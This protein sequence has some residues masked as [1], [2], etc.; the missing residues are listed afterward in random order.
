MPQD[1]PPVVSKPKGMDIT[2]KMKLKI[3]DL[4]AKNEHASKFT[5]DPDFFQMRVLEVGGLTTSIEMTTF[6]N[7][8]SETFGVY[9]PF[10]VF[11]ALSTDNPTVEEFFQDNVLSKKKQAPPSSANPP[12]RKPT[13]ESVKDND[14]KEGSSQ[15]CCV[16]S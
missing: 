9:I 2:K 14:K 16:I 15:S 10:S 8:I 6:Q 7:D 4:L 1:L 11:M 12:T 13:K 3:I 5:S